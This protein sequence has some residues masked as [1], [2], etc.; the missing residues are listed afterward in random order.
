M[1]VEVKG[2]EGEGEGEGGSI[3]TF[4]EI[5]GELHCWGKGQRCNN[6][7]NSSGW[8]NIPLLRREGGG[9]S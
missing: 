6:G 1:I 8:W 4:G 7:I 2:G 9:S 5:E 3:S